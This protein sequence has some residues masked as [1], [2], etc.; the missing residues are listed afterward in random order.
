MQV[1]GSEFPGRN[2]AESNSLEI[3]LGRV[4]LESASGTSKIGPIGV[5]PVL[6]SPSD[7]DP[8]GQV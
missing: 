6:A 7:N 2:T 3:Q 1:S 8:I 5:D 4:V